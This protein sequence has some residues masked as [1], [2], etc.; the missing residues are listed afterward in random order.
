MQ[1]SATDT[2][3][4]IRL[5]ADMAD[6]IYR[7]QGVMKP[8]EADKARQARKLI[9]KCKPSK[10]PAASAPTTEPTTATSE[11]PA[12]AAAPAGASRARTGTTL[13]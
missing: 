1:L 9:K 4:I 13:K 6:I 5:C 8:R 11:P 2:E 10:K 12:Q 7:Y 3:R